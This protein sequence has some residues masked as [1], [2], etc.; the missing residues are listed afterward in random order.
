MY[1]ACSMELESSFTNSASSPASFD[2]T[3]ATSLVTDAEALFHKENVHLAEFYDIVAFILT[4]R[5]DFKSAFQVKN[6]IVGCFDCNCYM[7]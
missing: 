6:L 7:V 3:R 2:M 4:N 5:N 1:D